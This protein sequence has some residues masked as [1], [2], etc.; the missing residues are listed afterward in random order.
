MKNPKAPKNILIT[1]ASS[2][3]GSALAVEY[4]KD[5]VTLLL[6]GR[7]ENR[8]RKIAVKCRE[9]GAEAEISV[10]DVTDRCAMHDAIFDLDNK[11]P[12]DLA[13]ANAGISGVSGGAEDPTE[14]I[15]N[16]F[17]VNVNGVLNTILPAAEKMKERKFGQIAIMSSLDRKSVV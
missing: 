10:V 13:I 9:K 3:I 15:Y 16:G 7:D 14:E 8:L 4:A 1:G 2:G 6:M 12:I 11:Y 17:N 5:G